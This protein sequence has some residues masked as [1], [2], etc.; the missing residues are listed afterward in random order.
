ME[1]FGYSKWNGM[2][3]TTLIRTESLIIIAQL[4]CKQWGKKT[5]ILELINGDSSRID[6]LGDYRLENV[7]H[8]HPHIVLFPSRTQNIKEKSADKK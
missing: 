3:L 1:C 2:K 4:F 6:V 7:A 8:L 5:L